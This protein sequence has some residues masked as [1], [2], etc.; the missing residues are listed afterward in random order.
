MSRSDRAW[1]TAVRAYGIDP[2][3]RVRPSVR[4]WLLYA[5]WRPL[6]DRHRNWVLYDTTCSTWVLRHFARILTVVAIPTA[7]I[8][9]F[10]PAPL[11]L[12]LTTAVVTAGM[13]VLLTGVW[14]N[15]ATEQRLLQAGWPW[16]F[17]STLRQER[18]AMA[19]RLP[20][21]RSD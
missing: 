18:S 11:G 2:E 4:R 7:A 20:R 9:V 15:E 16:Q 13:A 21:R 6:P 8:A 10:L 14:V 5:F 3:P 12:R 1:E 19:R 17:A